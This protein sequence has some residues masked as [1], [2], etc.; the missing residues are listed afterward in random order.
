VVIINLIQTVPVEPFPVTRPRDAGGP[1]RPSV[2]APYSPAP[3]NP[4]PFPNQYERNP[5]IT[6]RNGLLVN[7]NRKLRDSS[8]SERTSGI[9]TPTLPPFDIPTQ[10]DGDGKSNKASE[11]VTVLTQPTGLRHNNE[12]LDLVILGEGTRNTR[13]ANNTNPFINIYEYKFILF[14]AATGKIVII[15]SNGTVTTEKANPNAIGEF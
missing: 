2:R 5:Q 11:S 14:A 3:G 6:R 9:I 4:S 12:S 10:Y 15:N 1:L 13:S 8:H 7:T